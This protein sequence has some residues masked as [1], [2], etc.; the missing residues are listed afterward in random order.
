MHVHDRQISCEEDPEYK[1][2]ANLSQ[3]KWDNSA[4]E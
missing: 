3:L 2:A 1:N 4:Y